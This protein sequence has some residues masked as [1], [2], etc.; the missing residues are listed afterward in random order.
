MSLKMVAL[1]RCKKSGAYIARKG[2]PADIRQAHQQ[3]YGSYWET[4]FYAGG[5]VSAE[6]AKRRFA[7]WQAEVS[8]RITSLRRTAR[9]EGRALTHRE[10]HALAGEWYTWFVALNETEPGSVSQWEDLACETLLARLTNAPKDY[11]ARPEDREALDRDVTNRLAVRAHVADRALTGRFLLERGIVLTPEG[12]HRFLDAVAPEL[13]MVALRL[14]R[15]AQG[16]YMPDDRA[17]RFPKYLPARSSGMTCWQLFEAWIGERKPKPS[18]VDR[19]RAVFLDLRERFG[20]RD[21][22]SISD[23]DAITWKDHLVVPRR[24]GRTINDVWLATAKGVFQWAV[25]N[26]KI[27]SNPF[28]GL[29]VAYAKAPQERESRAFTKD[30]A[31]TILGAALAT[32]PR[33]LSPH[34]RAARRWVP[35]LSAY[36]GAR[37]QEIT[38]LRAEDVVEQ[39]GTWALRL[40]PSAGTLKTGQARTVPLHEHLVAQGFID[41]ARSVGKGPLFYDGEAQAAQRQSD[42]TNPQKALAVKTREHL[43]AWVRRI[44][45]DD[46]ELSPNHSWRHLF[47]E[48]ADRCGML[49]KVSDAITGH[50]PATVGRSYGRPTLEVMAQELVKFP[51]FRLRTSAAGGCAADGT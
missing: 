5:N 48:I 24:S 8:A 21:I 41:F 31:S 44:G 50:A 45:V 3:L 27:A 51:R 9:G 32:Q 13:E 33:R 43:A 10:A 14:A 35:W 39:G 49:E 19:R 47:K 26:R 36:T 34:Y 29:R 40:V 38:Q 1:I 4:K 15:H 12:R 22:A 23:E 7:E 25:T 28:R 11:Q 6:E 37:A 18:T 30:E 20:D 2:I 46:P 17:A 42:P 16:D